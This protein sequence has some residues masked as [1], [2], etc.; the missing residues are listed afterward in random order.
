MAK[1]KPS[2]VEISGKLNDL[3][4]VDSR[5][6]GRYVRKVVAKG[7]K[8]KEPALHAQYSRTKFLNDVASDVNTII[9]DNSGNLKPSSFYTSL[10]S[11]F[12]KEP[13]NNRFLLLRQLVGMEINSVYKL[14][15]LIRYN[16]SVQS[17]KDKI[18]VNLQVTANPGPGKHKADCCCYEVLMVSWTKKKKAATCVAQLSDWMYMKDGRPEFDFEFP[19]ENGLMHWMACVRVILG[20][21]GTELGMMVGQ[22]MVV[23]AVGSEVKADWEVV[24][25]REKTNTKPQST[26]QTNKVRPEAARV[27]AS[28]V[29]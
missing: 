10:Q 11:R 16:L 19:R 14:E 5:T 27:K 12:R 20:V 4:H 26:S 24:N 21:K 15:K 2:I 9:K 18:M 22:G 3:V 8:R 13:L 17:L 7:S 29:V 28:R 25:Q 23:A 1:L 6:N